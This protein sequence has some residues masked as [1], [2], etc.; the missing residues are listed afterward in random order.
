MVNGPPILGPQEDSAS[1]AHSLAFLKG[2]AEAS[3]VFAAFTFV[4]GWSYLASYYGAFG[5]NVLEID[6]GVPVVSTIF[7]HLLYNTP[8]KWPLIVITLLVAIREI[9]PAQLRSRLA[10]TTP[11]ILCLLLFLTASAGLARGQSRALDDMTDE[12]DALPLVAFNSKS[13]SEDLPSCVRHAIYGSPECKLLLHS[14]G[15]YFFFRPI[16]GPGKGT[17]DATAV[18]LFILP[19]SEVAGVYV[20]RGISRSEE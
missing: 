14:K 11:P 2:L 19:D 7:V 6:A 20:Q 13:D 17:I 8:W 5:L 9:L 4:G 3:A 15:N 10:I 16:P 18:D 12:S 1:Y